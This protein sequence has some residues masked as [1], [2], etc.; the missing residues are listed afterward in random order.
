MDD[1]RKENTRGNVI[2]ILIQRVQCR[3]A[4]SFFTRIVVIRSRSNVFNWILNSIR[5]LSRTRSVD[6]KEISRN[7][8][9]LSLSLFF[10]SYA[11]H[12]NFDLFHRSKVC[13]LTAITRCLSRNNYI[14]TPF[15]FFSKEN[16]RR[17]WKDSKF[18]PVV[19]NVAWMGRNIF[20]KFS[21]HFSSL[22]NDVRYLEM[23]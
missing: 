1:W 15:F 10:F 6:T 2:L 7:S 16:F 5:N 12:S 14:I 11:F 4:P 17:L 20:F 18:P 19:Y 3:V 23:S 13:Y 21:Y 8:C 9:Y 22:S